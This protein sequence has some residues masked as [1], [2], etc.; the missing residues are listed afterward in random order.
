MMDD[1]TTH[2]WSDGQAMHVGVVNGQH[3]GVSASGFDRHHARADTND[4]RSWIGRC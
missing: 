4:D 2:A 1:R 3:A